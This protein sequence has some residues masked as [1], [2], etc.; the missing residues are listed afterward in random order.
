MNILVINGS[1]KGKKSNSYKLTQ[2]LLEGMKLK[3]AEQGEVCSIEELAVNRLDIKPCLGCFSCWNKTPGQC[4]IRDDMAD[5]ITKL[6]WADITIW[7]F[8]LYYFNVPGGL[9]NLI[10][11]QLP[12]VLPFMEERED[13][14]GN[15]SHPSRYD[16]SRK[17]TVLVSTCGFYTAEGNYDGVCSLFDH[18]CG[19]D[20]YTAIFCGQGELFRVPELSKRTNE[21]L[22]WVTQAGEELIVSGAITKTTREKLD[23]ILYP[24]EIFESMADT[25]W[26]IDKES[27]EKETDALIF[28]RQMAVLYDKEAWKG[29]DQILEMYYTDLDERYQIVLSRDGSQ[30][31]KEH[32]KAATTIIETPFSVWQSIAA[33]EIRGDEALMKGLYKVKGDFNLMLEWDDYFGSTGASGKQE[34]LSETGEHSSQKT[35][36]MHVPDRQ[37]N[38]SILL[39]P[40]MALWIAVPIRNFTGSLIAV[41]VCALMQLLFYRNKKTVYDALSSALVTCFS[42]AILA[43]AAERIVIPL[44]YLAFG[45]MWTASCFC[46]ISL[47]AH[48]SLNDYHGESALQN[49]LFLKTNWILTLLWGILY[50]LTPIWTFLLM[51]TEVRSFTGAINS[52]FPI[53]MGIFTVWFQ[54]WYP[55]RIARGG[56]RE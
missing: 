26:G 36:M 37:T 12:M 52:I 11:R 43:G 25:S 41:G 50:L 34:N 46:K 28:T 17:K 29:R 40:W 24:K 33:G 16:M 31:L 13:Q 27:G 18:M 20:R 9:K 42:L 2:A 7:S 39:L 35:E 30:V 15:G 53:F 19:K 32:L 6:L 49:P 54:K 38:M 44:S 23:E 47:T 5:V 4:C 1:P 8:P 51:G 14:V 48:Y 3:T 45:I 10:D 56:S 22:E 55:A 21:Y